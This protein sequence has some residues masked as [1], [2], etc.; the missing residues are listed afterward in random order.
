VPSLLR[1]AR[2]GRTRRRR[3]GRPV[4]EAA[5]ALAPRVGHIPS[6]P[7]S[8]TLPSRQPV[9]IACRHRRETRPRRQRQCFVNINHTPAPAR[10]GECPARH[11]PCSTLR[12][13][14][15]PARRCSIRGRMR[16]S[17]EGREPIFMKHAASRELYCLLG[18][19]ARPTRGAG[20]RGDRAWRHS[21]RAERCLHPLARRGPRPSDPARRYQGMRAVRPRAQRRAIST[22]LG[23]GQPDDHRGPARDPRRRTHRHHCRRDRAESRRRCP[24]SRTPAVAARRATAEFRPCHRCAGAARSSAMA[25]HEPARSAH[26]RQPPPRRRGSRKTPAPA[27]PGA[28]GPPWSRRLRWRPFLAVSSPAQ[29]ASA[30][31][32]ANGPL[33]SRAYAGL[34]GTGEGVWR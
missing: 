3:S 33:T 6:P 13:A 24:R 4:R 1:P 22:A 34:R 7:V 20:A 18:R 11:A 14:A 30:L 28:A 8:R 5:P 31:T 17:R 29:Q 15:D 19:A 12:N 26:A 25:W 23:G 10:C 9:N 32:P 21:R 27:L 16:R 2:G